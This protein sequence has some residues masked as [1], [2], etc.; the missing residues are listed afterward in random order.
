MYESALE[1]LNERLARYL[2]MAQ[3]AGFAISGYTALRMAFAQGRIVCL[4]FATDIAETRKQ[5]YQEWCVRHR[6]P[7]LICFT[8]TRLGK[9]IGKS[10]RSAVG[11]TESRFYKLLSATK[12][13][14]DTLQSRDPSA[15]T[16]S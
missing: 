15:Q 11:L 8:K 9:I 4:V 2:S 12:A 7:A 14:L 10:S 3:K 1:L 5:V 16:K 6:I 13:S